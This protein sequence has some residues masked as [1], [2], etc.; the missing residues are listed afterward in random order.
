M[1]R[2]GSVWDVVID[3]TVPF[4][5]IRDAPAVYNWFSDAG[6]TIG[7]ILKFI[8]P[9]VALWPGVG[10]AL[11][12]ALSAAAAYACGEDSWSTPA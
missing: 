2:I 12:V 5:A 1:R 6:A 11:S 9:I 10:T 3:F 8:A 4:A 7:Q